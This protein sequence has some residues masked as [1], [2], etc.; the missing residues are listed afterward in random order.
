MKSNP[1]FKKFVDTVEE[2]LYG[3]NPNGAVEFSAQEIFDTMY[4][5]Y[6]KNK[7]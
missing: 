1:L 3:R 6:R 4:S 2:E 7:K 5:Q